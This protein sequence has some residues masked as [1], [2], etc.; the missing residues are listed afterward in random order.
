MKRI[1]YWQV[2]FIAWSLVLCFMFGVIVLRPLLVYT[3][4]VYAFVLIGATAVFSHVIRWV[5][6]RVLERLPMMQQALVLLLLSMLGAAV[7]TGLL[8]MSVFAISYT[9]FA[10]PI[11]SQQRWFVVQQV[12]IGNW[13]NM[14][15]LLVIW[16]SL[17]FAIHKVR[18]LKATTRALEQTQLEVLQNQLNPH[19]LFNALNNIR[20]LMLEDRDKSRDMLSCLSDMLRYSLS[21]DKQ[22]KVSLDEELRFIDNYISLCKIQF[23]S[24]LDYTANIDNQVRQ[25][26]V[27]RMILQLCVE[28]AV[29]HGVETSINGG[30]V[31]VS[32]RQHE[33]RLNLTVVNSV[34]EVHHRSASLGIGINNLQSRIQLIYGDA[35]V[36]DTT[37]RNQQFEVNIEIPMQ[38]K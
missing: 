2:Q 27:P 33:H 22:A 26:L 16:S 11:P 5:F 17:Y 31:I 6:K 23:E 9:P 34:P 37:H 20:A 1:T 3:E 38:S 8:V 14:S 21:K 13:I 18:I 12:F 36:C 35:G 32:A 10:F 19:F 29:K 30:F 4:F 7:S 24:R 15:A 25:C 28:N